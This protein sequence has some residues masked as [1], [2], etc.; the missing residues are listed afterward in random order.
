MNLW[1]RVLC[2]RRSFLRGCTA[3]RPSV[4]VL[5][6]AEGGGVAQSESGSPLNVFFGRP[7]HYSLM[8]RQGSTAMASKCFRLARGKYHIINARAQNVFQRA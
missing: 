2:L 8:K 1:I 7:F 6:W 5:G 3:V 4:C